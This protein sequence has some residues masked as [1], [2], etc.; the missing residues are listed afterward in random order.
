MVEVDGMSK[1][2]VSGIDDNLRIEANP[3]SL[4]FL[5]YS[6]LYRYFGV[7]NTKKFIYALIRSPGFQFSFFMRICSR[8]KLGNPNIFKRICYRLNWEIL[9]HIS[10]KYGLMIQPYVK[11]APGLY[12]E[13]FGGIFINAI[14]IGKNCNITPG[15]IIGVR[16]RGSKKGIPT[17][18]DN[19]FIGPGSVIFGNI[20][21]G[22]NVAIG[23]NT[24]V[25]TDIPDNAVVIGNPGVIVSYNGSGGYI[26][27][28]DYEK[29]W[30]NKR[31][32]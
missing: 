6:D 5:W 13:H 1:T 31:G 26:N 19:V 18:G 9:R 29:Y 4:R 3:E 20:N 14:S 15:V 2:L 32:S 16:N 10:I 8:L 24:V 23:A 28:V 25:N 17:I 12:V 11:V 7:V 22:N 30:T 27:H 21:I